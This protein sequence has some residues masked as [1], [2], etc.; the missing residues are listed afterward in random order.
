MA[1]IPPKERHRETECMVKQDPSFRCIQETH[2]NI[3]DRHH[4][5]INDRKR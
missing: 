1:T 2:L 4:L 5:R 3:K